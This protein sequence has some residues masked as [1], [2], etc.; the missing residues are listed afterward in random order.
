MLN[1][2][3]FDDFYIRHAIDE[4]PDSNLYSMHIHDQCEIYLF[5][6]GKV[7]YL[8]E[9]VKYPLEENN[10]MLM[11][12]SEAHV[13][14]I[15]DKEVYERYAINFPLTFASDIDPEGRLLRAFTQR[16]LGKNNKVTLSAENGRLARQL[17]EKMSEKTDDYARRL[18]IKTNLFTLLNLANDAFDKNMDDAEGPAEKGEKLVAYVNRHLFEELSVPK[19]AAHFYLSPSQFSRLFKHATG[20]APWDYVI[21]KRL[22]EAKEKIREGE[23]A[24]SA[25]AKCGFNDYSSFYRAFKKQFGCSPV[26]S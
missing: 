23:S 7:E 26:G 15:L 9:G 5:V 1:E 6:S 25:A 3:W 2:Y 4:K 19:M 22:T 14:R 12:P 24:Q 20:A 13:A 16:P 21:K 8:V 10:L 11:R 17:F 18:N